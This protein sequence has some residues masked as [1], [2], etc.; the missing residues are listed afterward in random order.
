[1]I[2]QY[3]CPGELLDKQLVTGP[4]HWNLKYVYLQDLQ[5]LLCAHLKIHSNSNRQCPNASVIQTIQTRAH[6]TIS[7]SNYF[8]ICNVCATYGPSYILTPSLCLLKHD[9]RRS[10]CIV[11]Y[12]FVCTNLTM[13]SA[14]RLSLL[15]FFD[16]CSVISIAS[17][18]CQESTT[19]CPHPSRSRSRVK[20]TLFMQPRVV[21]T[22]QR[23]SALFE[24]TTTYDHPTRSK[25]RRL[26]QKARKKQERK[27]NIELKKKRKKKKKTNQK[28]KEKTHN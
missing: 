10:L 22:R 26:V 9:T 17:R 5:H 25:M 2:N 20:K 8:K 24:F 23:L 27:D 13:G 6:A 15:S 3:L 4:S 16:T 7:M 28:T 18:H 14:S 12:N 19:G 21:R 11:K 1:M